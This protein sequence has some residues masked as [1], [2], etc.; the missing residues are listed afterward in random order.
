MN[1]NIVTHLTPEG[2][3]GILLNSQKNVIVQLL[4]I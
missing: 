1:M 4:E 2:I 3:T